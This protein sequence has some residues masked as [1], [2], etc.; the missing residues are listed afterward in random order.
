MKKPTKR[1][2]HSFEE[3]ACVAAALYS[4]LGLKVLYSPVVDLKNSRILSSRPLYCWR[5]ASSLPSSSET[6]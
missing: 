2:G 3:T 4:P 1:I 5:R 6:D